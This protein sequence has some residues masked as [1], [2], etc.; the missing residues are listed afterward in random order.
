MTAGP[1]RR[2]VPKSLADRL[3]GVRKL[4]TE[5]RD[6]AQNQLLF[7][8]GASCDFICYNKIRE[9][10]TEAVEVLREVDRQ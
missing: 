10:L 2:D 3:D 7:V 8:S 5:A 1:L 4:A 9:L 6:L